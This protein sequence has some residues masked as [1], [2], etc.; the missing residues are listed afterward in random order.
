MAYK[1]T[2]GW[3]IKA[4]GHKRSNW[5]G[6]VLEHILIAERVLGKP[7][8]KK[9]VV[10]HVD[11]NKFNNKNNNLALCQDNGYHLLLHK[12]KRALEACGHANWIKCYICKKWDSPDNLDNHGR[13]KTCHVTE[14]MG[15]VPVTHYKKRRS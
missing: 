14:V 11:L 7:L 8:P 3:M 4:V 5:Q 1:Q 13:H 15:K 2:M 12:R 10:H 9:A 6:F